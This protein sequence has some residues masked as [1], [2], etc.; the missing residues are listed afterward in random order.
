MSNDDNAKILGRWLEEP[1]GTAPPDAL[2]RVVV[3]AVY[4]LRPDL[5]PAPRLSADDILA[6][7]SAGPFATSTAEAS[8]EVEDSE[9]AEVVP[10]P[11]GDPE[12]EEPTPDASEPRTRSTAWRWVG[13]T[14]GLG[15]ALVAA[16]TLLVV[17]TP[18]LGEPP[19]AAE[20]A[21]SPAAQAPARRGATLAEDEAGRPQPTRPA[22][23]RVATSAPRAPTPD[24][25]IYDMDETPAQPRP[26]TVIPEVAVA[27]STPAEPADPVGGVVT[28][29]GSDAVAMIDDDELDDFAD[30]EAE[31]AVALRA[32]PERQQTTGYQYTTDDVEAKADA[33]DPVEQARQRLQAGDRRGAANLFALA[34]QPPAKRT[35]R[36]GIEAATIYLELGD[37]AAAEA[38]VVKALALSGGKRS[39]RAE[40]EG[41]LSRARGEPP[42]DE[43]ESTASQPAPDQD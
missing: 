14:S 36:W 16:A 13:G 1:S 4:A 10:F 38:V 31:E 40:L 11:G 30:S 34:V 18:G 39:E 23:P 5:A 3:E 24:E 19:P 37:R 21:A 20:Q 6:D 33:G 32:S 22:R 43:V 27:S 8:D 17:L 42:A 26:S 41:L 35:L 7:V 9:G 12:S 29:L 25:P 15:L 28:D 2:D